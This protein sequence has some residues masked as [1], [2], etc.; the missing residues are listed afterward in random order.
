VASQGHYDEAALEVLLAANLGFVGLVASRK[1][2]ARVFGVLEQQGCSR[3]RIATVR[4][5]VGLDLG[6]RTPQDVA[7]SILA[8]MVAHAARAGGEAL[9]APG[10]DAPAE[11]C[12][13]KLAVDPM[14]GMDVEIEGARH[15]YELGGRTYYFCCAGCRSAFAAD[16]VSALAASGNA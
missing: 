14:C 5:P 3:E 2:A 8:E 1:R 13:S 15:H 7:V 12:A 11:T 10:D 6:A 4:N 16:P 9:S